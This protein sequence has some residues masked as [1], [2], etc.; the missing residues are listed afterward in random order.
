MLRHINKLAALSVIAMAIG[1]AVPASAGVL[2]TGTGAMPGWFGET[3][4]MDGGGMYF[5]AGVEFAV[6]APGV[7]DT[8]FGSGADPSGGTEV[9][10]AYQFF[11]YGPLTGAPLVKVTVGLDA[12][13]PF[14]GSPLGNVGFLAGTGTFAPNPTSGAI[15]ADLFSVRWD[16]LSPNMI[17]TGQNSD[18]LIYT[19][20]TLPEWGNV[21]AQ[22]AY[23]LQHTVLASVPNPGLT[24]VPEPGTMALVMVGG[25][26]LLRKRRANR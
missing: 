2:E 15:A 11:N 7:F 25:I 14:T 10:Y 17:G 4:I 22:N 9:V 20:P 24:F 8:V 18:I 5:N 6:Y 21:A 1:F 12:N 19:C 23:G 13:E 3:T 16:F 26:A